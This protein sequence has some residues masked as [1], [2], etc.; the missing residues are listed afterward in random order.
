MLTYDT[1]KGKT[2]MLTYDTEKGKTMMLLGNTEQNKLRRYHM[3]LNKKAY[4]M[5]LPHD[6]E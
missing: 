4:S 1:E 5:A 6:T 3:I 2:M